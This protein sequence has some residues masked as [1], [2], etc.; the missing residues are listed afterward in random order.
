VSREQ[1]V[2][3][4][5]LG[6][7]GGVAALGYVLAVRPWFLRWGATEAETREILPG[8]GLVPDPKHCDTHAITV[9]APVAEVR[10]WLVQFGSTTG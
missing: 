9:H 8:N 7:L 10:P 1:A 5:A 4:A 3:R 2:R 6:A